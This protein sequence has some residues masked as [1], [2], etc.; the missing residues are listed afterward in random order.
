[1]ELII[2]RGAKEIGGSAVE[3][4]SRGARV[5][6]DLGMSLDADRREDL[7][8]IDGL[9]KGS[10]PKFDAILLSHAHLDHWGLLPHAHPQI[11]IY[12][13]PGSKV[14]LEVSAEYLHQKKPNGEMHTFA[15]G[16]PLRIGDM[17]ITPHLMDHSAYDAAAFEIAADE[18]RI[19]YTGDFRDHG[20]KP[21]ALERFL[22]AVFPRPD[23]LLCEGTTLGRSGGTAQT[24]QALEEAIARKLC[25]TDGIALFQCA[26][27]NIDRLVTFY[28]AARR[29]G[30]T[31][32]I[33]AYT[34]EV[35]ARLNKATTSIPSVGT[36]KGLSRFAPRD[37]RKTLRLVRPSMLPKLAASKAIHG[38]IFIYSLWQGYRDQEKQKAF[39]AFL[40]ERGFEMAVMHTSGHADART[41]KA[42][43]E[44]LEP[45][46]VIPIHSFAP[47]G[48]K[49]F[50]EKVVLAEDGELITI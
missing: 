2:H 22:K 24:E 40:A 34:A 35:L 1:M 21:G 14:L 16:E 26:G 30:R 45:K 37:A 43:I 6:L 27:Q 15:M 36:H 10:M 31:M 38:G 46:R 25:A 20:R 8:A 32:V 5:L 49:E 23:A 7:P 41:L 42:V 28:K 44:R 9:Y 11:P 4:R 39:E 3:L 33:D 19:V 18:Q 17:T 12:L 29:S 47:E 48:F 13:S 50:T